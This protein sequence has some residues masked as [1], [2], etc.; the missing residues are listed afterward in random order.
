MSKEGGQEDAIW[1]NRK[2][3]EKEEQKNKE[4]REGDNC[5]YRVGKMR[6]MSNR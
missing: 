4:K 1:K 3:G 6:R 5:E 2:K